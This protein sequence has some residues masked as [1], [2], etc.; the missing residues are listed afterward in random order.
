MFSLR[1]AS[2]LR[3]PFAWSWSGQDFVGWSLRLK[4]IVSKKI[5]DNREK[6]E[7]VSGWRSERLNSCKFGLRIALAMNLISA[8]N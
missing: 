2:F 6:E 4:V 5:L 7:K 1:V 8:V 3:W